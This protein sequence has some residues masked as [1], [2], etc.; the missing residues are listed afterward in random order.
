MD[1]GGTEKQM[2]YF[3]VRKVTAGAMD[4][5]LALDYGA[6]NNLSISKQYRQQRH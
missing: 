3:R 6:V 2:C 4:E 5:K 1:Y